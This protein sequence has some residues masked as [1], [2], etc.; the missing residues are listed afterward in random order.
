MLTNLSRKRKNSCRSHY[1]Q[2]IFLQNKISRRCQTYK[3]YFLNFEIE[4]REILK[5]VEVFI[6]Q[7]FKEVSHILELHLRFQKILMST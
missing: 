4:F 2:L 1:A 5:H 3:N 6:M 7:L